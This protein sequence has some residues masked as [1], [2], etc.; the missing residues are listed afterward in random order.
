[1]SGAWKLLYEFNTFEQAQFALQTL[2]ENGVSCL[3]L[4]EHSSKFVN[5]FRTHGGVRLLVEKND[6]TKAQEILTNIIEYKPVPS[7]LDWLDDQLEWFPLKINVVYKI[8]ILGII[9]S[10]SISVVISLLDS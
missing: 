6:L 9:F 5:Y 7:T 8:L 10:I 2:E 1:M 3:L 4:D